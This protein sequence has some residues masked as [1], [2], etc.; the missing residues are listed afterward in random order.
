MTN[1]DTFAT[2]YREELHR[3]VSTNPANYPWFPSRSVDTVADKMIAAFAAGT[4]N[5]D[6]EAIKAACKR[7]GIPHTRR[8]MLT[9]FGL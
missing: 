1:L 4:F 8:A 9:Y 3:A 6:G 5:H 7:L 2:V